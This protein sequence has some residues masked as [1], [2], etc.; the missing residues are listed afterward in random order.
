M[1]TIIFKLIEIIIKTVI[2]LCC[3]LS[4]LIWIVLFTFYALN[5]F[6]IDFIAMNACSDN[7]RV[8]SYQEKI[9]MWV[10]EEKR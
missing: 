1:K 10:N 3:S 4:V 6:N 5:D 7:A 9:C 2:V 8:W